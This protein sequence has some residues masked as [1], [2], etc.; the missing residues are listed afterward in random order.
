MPSL[1]LVTKGGF[2]NLPEKVDPLR[3]S[4]HENSARYFGCAVNVNRGHLRI[5]SLFA[6]C[7]F[8]MCHLSIDVDLIVAF[9]S[10]FEFSTSCSYAFLQPR[11]GKYGCA[12][13]GPFLYRYRFESKKT[14]DFG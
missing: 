7:G 5:G 9:L 6:S 1:F 3:A 2:L 11:A 4:L 10:V 14:C 12:S 13:L 8:L